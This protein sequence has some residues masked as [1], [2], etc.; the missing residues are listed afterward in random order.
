M[1]IVPC[2]GCTLC[3]KGDTIR[4][5]PEDNPLAYQTEPHERFPGELMLAHK[6]NGDCVYLG[7]SGCTIQETKPAMCRTMDC[8]AIFLHYPNQRKFMRAKRTGIPLSFDLWNRGKE[9]QKQEPITRK[10]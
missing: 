9:L 3:C 10:K 2:N 6:E 8:R 5:L 7:E 4:L 1:T